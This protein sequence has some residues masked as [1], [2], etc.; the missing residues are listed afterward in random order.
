MG[1]VN[2]IKLLRQCNLLCD[3]Y[4]IDAINVTIAGIAL[5]L[6]TGEEKIEGER[7]RDHC[8]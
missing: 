1:Q 8:R 6:A 7:E 4:S 2:K 3:L 5:T